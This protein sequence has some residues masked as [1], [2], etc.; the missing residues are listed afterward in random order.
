VIGTAL[1]PMAPDPTAPDP[2]APVRQL[3][4]NMAR[5]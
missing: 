3:V 1:D 2:T 5:N 4:I